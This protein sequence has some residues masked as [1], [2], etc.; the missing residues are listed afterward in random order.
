[1]AI[2]ASKSRT[3]ALLSVRD[4]RT[5]IH[6]PRGVVSAVDGV[7]FD[8]MPG[9]ILGIV[10][11]SGSGKTMT[12]L[13]IAGLLP[14]PPAEIKSGSIEMNGRD[15]LLLPES[16]MREVRGQE[17]SMVFQ[18][19]LTSLNPLMKVGDQISETIWVHRRTDRKSARETALE[20]LRQVGM[21]EPEARASEYPFEL[22]GGMR[23][24]VMIAIA[25][26][27]SP[28]LIIAD[29]PTT[30]LDATIQ[31]QILSLLKSIRDTK[32]TSI[33]LITHNLGI[34]AWVCD[35]VA[36]MYAGR[37]VEIG[38]TQQVL[39]NPLHPYTKALI[40][41][42]PR[43]DTA[44]RLEAI[45]GDIPSLINMP[46]ACNFN[47]R[48]PLARDVCRKKDPPTVEVEKSH[49]ADCF[50]YTEDWQEAS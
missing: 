35:R 5:Q 9:E 40:S 14:S 16:E 38:P 45:P 20:I 37:L 21:P 49:S 3:D 10:G 24:R 23:Q 2:E 12:A 11:E 25:I 46:E 13:S 8:I 15:L 18:D 48:C 4:L 19:P 27:A 39:A 34:V 29:E 6:T 50:V 28:K 26:A 36:V 17:I 41:A 1:L 7:S 44:G 47:P 31:A 30:N 42:I 32:G 43:I 22:S 33:L